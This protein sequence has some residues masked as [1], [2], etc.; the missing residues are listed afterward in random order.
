MGAAIV[1]QKEVI[2]EYLQRIQDKIK[3]AEDNMIRLML[4]EGVKCSYFAYNAIYYE[5]G[6]GISTGKDSK[7]RNVLKQEWD[8]MTKYICVCCKNSIIEKM[9]KNYYSPDEKESAIKSKIYNIL[10]KIDIYLYGKRCKG[11]K[12]LSSE[13]DLCY[14]DNLR[15]SI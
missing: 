8:W 2:Y 15:N 7:Y 13:D 5:W 10:A 14:L 4:L 12:R 6:D 3:Y 9:I 11:K 1:G